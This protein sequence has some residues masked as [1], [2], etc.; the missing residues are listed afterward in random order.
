[1]AELSKNKP[2]WQPKVGGNRSRRVGDL[3]DKLSRSQMTVVADY[4]GMKMAELS[5]LRRQLRA[6]NTEFHIVKNT[7]VGIAG[8]KAGIDVL[9]PVLSGTTAVAFC[10]GDVTAPAKV[11]ND[12]ARTSKFLKIKGTLLQGQLLSPDQLGAVANLPSKEVLRSQLLGALQGPAAN[13][14]GVLNSAL[15]SFV[16]VLQARAQ[17]MG[18]GE[19]A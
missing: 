7:L 9:S 6:N 19:P 2:K 18:A 15:Q 13:L 16:G 8:S 5:E 12:Y 11:L 4:R 3:T 17:Q 10:Y 14:V 1:M